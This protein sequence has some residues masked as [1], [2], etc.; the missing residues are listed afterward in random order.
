VIQDLEDDAA[1]PRLAGMD[2][3]KGEVRRVEGRRVTRRFCFLGHTMDLSV[4]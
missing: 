4:N 3:E 2:G 1:V